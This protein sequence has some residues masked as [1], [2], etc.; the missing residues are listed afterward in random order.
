MLCMRNQLKKIRSNNLLIKVLSFIFG[1]C[2]WSMF[3]ARNVST[4]ELEVPL[5]FF[6]KP[7]SLQLQAPETITV[8]LSGKRSTLRALDRNTL[9]IH[10]DASRLHEGANPLVLENETLFLPSTIKLI[11]YIPANLVIH[12]QE[13]PHTERT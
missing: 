8:Q 2:V 6:N 12:A 7:T 3:S 10:I 4:M 9:A 5:C 1:Y 11:H 13:I